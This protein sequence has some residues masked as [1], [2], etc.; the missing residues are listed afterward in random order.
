MK[1]QIAFARLA[2]FFLQNVG[3]GFLPQDAKDKEKAADL[4]SADA[5]D[6]HRFTNHDKSTGDAG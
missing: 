4:T 2:V 6:F 5:K 1:S 3:N